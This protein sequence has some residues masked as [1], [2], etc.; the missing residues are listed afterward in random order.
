MAWKGVSRCSNTA[1]GVIGGVVMGDKIENLAQEA[2]GGV[3]S[4][5]SAFVWTVQR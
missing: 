2:L 1:A 3:Q 5:W 4:E